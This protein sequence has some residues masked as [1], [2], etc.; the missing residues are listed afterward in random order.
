MPAVLFRFIA[1][2]TTP[3]KQVVSALA[4]LI[5][6]AAGACGPAPQAEPTA[7]LQ[8]ALV[9]TRIPRSAT[10]TVTP[11]PTETPTLTPS[12]TET[13]SPTPTHTPEPTAT[14]TET[15]SLTPS[16]ALT[17][18]AEAA[19]AVVATEQAIAAATSTS[20]FATAEAQLAATQTALALTQAAAVPSPTLTPT[21]A[22]VTTST[23]FNPIAITSTISLDTAVSGMIAFPQFMQVYAYEGVV[24]ERI[25]IEVLTS[26]GTL[27]PSIFVVDPK[28]R[29]VARYEVR[30]E[31]IS[32]GA[33]R[34]LEL[35]EAGTY[36]IGVTR[37][38]G[39]F[40]LTDGTFTLTVRESAPDQL[41]EGMFSEVVRYGEDVLGSL[42]LDEHGRVYSFRGSAGDRLNIT[43]TRSSNNLD[44]YLILTDS[45]GNVLAWNDDDMRTGLTDSAIGEYVLPADGYYSIVASRYF[46]SDNSGDFRLKITQ[47][48]SL[49]EPVVYG[50]LDPVSSRTVRADGQFFSNFSA[51]D[52]IATEDDGSTQELR[53]QSLIT[54]QI[55]PV[56]ADQVVRAE[57]RLQPC[58]ESRGGFTALGDMTVYADQYGSLLVRRD[59]TRVSTGAR[60]LS[61]Q[62]NCDPIDVTEVVRSLITEGQ[63]FTQ[64]RLVFRQ[65]P[66]NGQGDEILVTPSLVIE[67]TN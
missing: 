62:S 18:T 20:I 9:P 33:I 14:P 32:S 5:L 48:P 35:A 44:P 30:R 34:A 19:A 36:L 58:L 49:S 65:S 24:G 26:S 6:I 47:F 53:T 17:A 23:G 37:L 40:G 3:T 66:I 21:A 57:L 67:L 55:P 22:D 51:G 15:P 2:R 10:P 56:T 11:S 38:T 39:L 12:P 4:L 7:T 50:A 28:G 1:V 46:G 13:P 63:A 60:I 41:P 64:Y 59:F 61:T 8:G 52:S 54:F 45:L 27:S 43:M 25:D 31:L 29:E 16:P 42:S